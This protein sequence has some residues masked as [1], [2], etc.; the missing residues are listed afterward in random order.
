[1]KQPDTIPQAV[2]DSLVRWAKQHPSKVRDTITGEESVL[3]MPPSVEWDGMNGCYY[4]IRN[5]MYHGVELDGY[6][7]T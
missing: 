1:M 4:F 5:G 6:I 2:R 7:H 3:P